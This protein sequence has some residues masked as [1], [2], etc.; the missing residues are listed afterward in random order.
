VARQ[1][2][3]SPDMALTWNN[4]RLTSARIAQPL[5]ALA[6]SLAP[7]NPSESAATAGGRWLQAAVYDCKL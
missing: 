4:S 7:R 5:P 1:R 3:P 6:P 2:A